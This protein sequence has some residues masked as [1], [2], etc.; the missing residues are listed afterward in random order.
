MTAIRLRLALISLVCT[1]VFKISASHIIKVAMEHGNS[2]S[3][4]LVYPVAIDAVILISALTLTAAKGVNGMA[5]WWARIGRWF[6]FAAT[7]FCNMASSNFA[8]TMDAVIAL[9]PA[10]ALIITVE[11]LIHASKATPATRRNRK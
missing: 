6:G 8:S 10:I 4:A 11:L 2:H 1:G 7:I 5:K 3:D 9:I